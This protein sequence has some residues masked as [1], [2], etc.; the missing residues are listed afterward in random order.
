MAMYVGKTNGPYI[1]T[2]NTSLVVA[3]SYSRSFGFYIRF[4]VT[5]QSSS[6]QHILNCGGRGNNTLLC[7]SLHSGSLTFELGNGT[8]NPTTITNGH[9]QLNS[10]VDFECV[11]DITSSKYIINIYINGALADH[12]E[13]SIPD[14]S[15]IGNDVVLFNCADSS[16]Q[17]PA[18]I[19]FYFLK[20]YNNSNLVS[21]ITPY[22]VFNGTV[23]VL[24]D[25]GPYPLI[26]P[27][28]GTATFTAASDEAREVTKMYLSV[29]GTTKEVT[30]GYVGVNGTAKL[31]FGSATPPQPV[32]PF[33]NYTAT[34]KVLTDNTNP[35]VPEV[36]PQVEVF[37][38][39][40]VN[41]G[42]TSVY[43]NCIIISDVPDFSTTIDTWFA[44]SGMS[45]GRFVNIT[46]TNV[47][48]GIGTTAFSNPGYTPPGCELNHQYY[49][50]IVA[51]ILIDNVSGMT[52]PDIIIPLIS[53]YEDITP[54]VTPLAFETPTGSYNMSSDQGSLTVVFNQNIGLEQDT[55]EDPIQVML[56]DGQGTIQ[57]LVYYPGYSEEL[58]VVDNIMYL[59]LKGGSFLADMPADVR[60][61]IQE[62][63]VFS[64][65]T[66]EHLSYVESPVQLDITY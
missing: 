46:A 34:Y 22:D 41:L 27:L 39:G 20:T 5:T 35:S 38:P 65:V 48:T 64:T 66:Q 44:G 25:G 42:F 36:T 30:Q 7:L 63:V 23:R 28:S 53:Q 32:N 16:N 49:V 60:L 50:K 31:F 52:N 3:S 33:V 21:T 40:T 24:I 19:D 62:N 4:K 10:Y 9:V 59:D 2:T 58:K 45:Q 14:P 29:N 15:L 37:F 6:W 18:A 47:I 13:P 8:S 12:Q 54:Q 43:S 51:G 1:S 11:C 26:A 61:V 55:G 57:S 56:D 17:R